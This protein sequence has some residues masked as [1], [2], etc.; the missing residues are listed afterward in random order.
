M[1][2]DNKL[3]TERQLLNTRTSS[4]L[5]QV[6]FALC[7]TFSLLPLGLDWS[8]NATNTNIVE[9]SRFIQI[10]FGLLFLLAGIIVWNNQRV[11]LRHISHLNIFL[12]LFIAWCFI[13]MI[14][15]PYPFITFK[16][17]IQQLGLIAVGLAISPPILHKKQFSNTLLFIFT[18][19]LFTSLLA[20]LLFPSLGIDADLDH[21]W[22]GILPHK[23]VLGVVAALSIV[24]W[25]RNLLDKKVSP[26]IFTFF[27]TFSFMMLILSKATTPLLVGFFCI[28][29]Y[30]FIIKNP[31]SDSFFFTRLILLISSIILFSLWLF[32]TL[33]SSLPTWEQLFYPIE[34]FFNKSSTLTGRTDIWALVFL[35]I[36]EHPINGIGY[37][38]FWLGQDGPSQYVS[39][40]L[41]WVPMQAHNGYIDI[42][43]ELGI[44]GLGLFVG[45]VIVHIRNLFLLSKINKADA[46][47]HAIIFL[48]A[49]INN[50]SESDFFRG[51]LFKN[52]LFIFS[53][54]IVSAQ[55]TQEK[56]IVPPN[57]R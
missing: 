32:Y 33:N 13:S 24:L 46:A 5:A 19:L 44:V 22:R 55:L 31:F 34:F 26:L 51:L 43:N 3:V 23:N 38:A 41:H 15:S 47:L 10:Q 9:G 25:M 18:A 12:L 6:L 36:A 1:N 53:S 37:G 4:M 30:L 49:F 42:V 2:M 45:I 50:F 27:L 16:R 21:A 48:F 39:D 20:A 28:F 8:Q 11:S 56:N 52:M 17:A 54:V 29:L 14:W 40:I 7:I 57:T 35:S